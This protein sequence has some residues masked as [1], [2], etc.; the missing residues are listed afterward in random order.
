MKIGH[1]D[2][3]DECTKCGQMLECKLFRQR[4]GIGLER[5]NVTEMLRCQFRHERE[6]YNDSDVKSSSQTAF[7]DP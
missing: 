2:I 7:V 4:H 5:E 3:D 1:K 6:K